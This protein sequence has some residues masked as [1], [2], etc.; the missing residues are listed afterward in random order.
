MVNA[1]AYFDLYDTL[2]NEIVGS[3]ELFVILGI[4]L[5][6]LASRK[7][8]VNYFASILFNLVFVTIVLAVAYNPAWWAIVLLMVGLTFYM[9]MANV[10]KR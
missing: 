9:A 2:V 4:I 10:I 3:L 8:G 7:M 5:I 6:F 1:S